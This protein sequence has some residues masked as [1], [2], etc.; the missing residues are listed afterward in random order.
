MQSH[1]PQ[2]HHCLCSTTRTTVS[3][4]CCAT[5]VLIQTDKRSMVG[6]SCQTE[7]CMWYGAELCREAPPEGQVIGLVVFKPPSVKCEMGDIF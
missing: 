4:Y 2:T 7:A 3:L 6:R 1:H 5:S